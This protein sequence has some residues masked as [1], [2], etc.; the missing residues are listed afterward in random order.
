MWPNRQH[1]ADLVTLTA[2]ILNGK[3]H[4]F[5]QCHYINNLKKTFDERDQNLLFTRNNTT[6]KTPHTFFFQI[7]PFITKFY[8]FTIFFQVFISMLFEFWEGDLN[9]SQLTRRRYFQ[10][11]KVVLQIMVIFT[12]LFY[13]LN[14]FWFC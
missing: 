7:L 6:A 12:R 1:L 13:K 3:L 9:S 11:K 14:S 2:E 8:H 5:L 4:F 10:F